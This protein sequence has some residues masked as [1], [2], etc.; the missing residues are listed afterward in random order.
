MSRP[1]KQKIGYQ[2][3]KVLI[4]KSSDLGKFL[5]L[6]I[7]AKP[8]FDATTWCGHNFIMKK[9]NLIYFAFNPHLHFCVLNHR[10]QKYFGKVSFSPAEYPNRPPKVPLI[11][12]FKNCSEFQKFLIRPEMH[13][14][15]AF[16]CFCS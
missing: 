9:T 8:F 13:Y 3:K 7:F 12:N 4:T 5:A 2:I 6:K 14:L 11:F 10:D 16:F 15:D 1:K